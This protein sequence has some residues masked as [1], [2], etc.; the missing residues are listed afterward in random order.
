MTVTN[1]IAANELF[2]QCVEKTANMKKTGNS[3]SMAGS[4]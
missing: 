4:I 2:L 1:R 3:V